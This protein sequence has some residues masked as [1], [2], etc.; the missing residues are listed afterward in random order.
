M[1]TEAF[2]ITA[3]VGGGEGRRRASAPRLGRFEGAAVGPLDVRRALRGRVARGERLVGFGVVRRAR[4]SHE[5]AAAVAVG[6]IPGLGQLVMLIDGARHQSARRVLVLTDRRLLVMRADRRG[7]YADKAIEF[8]A[9]LGEVR[10][11]PMGLRRGPGGRGAGP[12]AGSMEALV[13]RRRR[14]PA[15]YEV[16][17]PVLGRRTIEVE[18]AGRRAGAR[19]LAQGLWALC[20]GRDAG[21]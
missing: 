10:V 2:P 14:V 11:A 7:R 20:D 21:V 13:S 17:L 12:A 16:V 1:K 5:A 4:P 8:E 9:A 6:S 3:Q 15:K 19:R 18:Q